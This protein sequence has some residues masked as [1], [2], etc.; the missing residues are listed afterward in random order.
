WDAAAA[1]QAE[2]SAEWT[3]SLRRAVWWRA[4]LTA[5]V[6]NIERRVAFVIG[7]LRLRLQPRVPWMAILGPNDNERTSLTNEV[8]HRF[9]A[10]PYGSVKALHW[11]SPLLRRPEGNEPMSDPHE[12]PRRGRIGASWRLLVLAADW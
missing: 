2:I 7:E 8:V 9:A 11:R 5:P 6:R 3:R 10:C 1:G 4:R 12:V